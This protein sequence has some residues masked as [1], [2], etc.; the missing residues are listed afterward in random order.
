MDIFL[1]RECFKLIVHPTY[2][3]FNLKYHYSWTIRLH[4]T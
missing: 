4:G 2:F 1:F 3:D